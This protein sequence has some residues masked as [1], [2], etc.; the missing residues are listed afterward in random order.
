M[1]LPLFVGNRPELNMRKSY[2][3]EFLIKF[4]FSGL[5]SRSRRLS[6]TLGSP[7]FRR[8]MPRPWLVCGPLWFGVRLSSLRKPV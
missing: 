4:G 2:L 7:L 1:R 6:P 5:S 8:R 3:R